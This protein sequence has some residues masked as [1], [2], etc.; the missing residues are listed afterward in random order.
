MIY[1]YNASRLLWKVY[2]NPPA[3]MLAAFRALTRSSP[4]SP[5]ILLSVRESVLPLLFRDAAETGVATDEAVLFTPLQA[6]PSVVCEGPV[7]P[8]ARWA[9]MLG[10]L[11]CIS[12]EF[13][14]SRTVGLTLVY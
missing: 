4:S 3:S 7:L 1:A 12:N 5:F 9:P 11:V 10:R 8:D 14:T 13:I 6:S 2:Q